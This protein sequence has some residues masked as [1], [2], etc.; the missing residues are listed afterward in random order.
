MG[1]AEDRGKHAK[2][3]ATSVPGSPG[4][5]PGMAS[6]VCVESKGWEELGLS[7]ESSSSVHQR[8]AP[9]TNV[10]LWPPSSITRLM[11]VVEM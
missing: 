10:C 2:K 8:Q 11:L 5:S 7:G 4:D 1:W 3:E 9:V 6:V